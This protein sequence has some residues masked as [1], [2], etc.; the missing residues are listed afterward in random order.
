VKRA[1]RHKPA[2]SFTGY[3]LRRDS[4]H[5]CRQLADIEAPDQA[6]L[7]VKDVADHLVRQHIAL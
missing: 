2:L 4:E 3:L 6:V 7:Y 1:G 5:W